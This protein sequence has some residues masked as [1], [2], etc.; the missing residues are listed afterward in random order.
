MDSDRMEGVVERWSAS[1][2]QN[3]HR[4]T[5]KNVLAYRPVVVDAARLIAVLSAPILRFYKTIYLII[6][7]PRQFADQSLLLGD[8]TNFIR[9]AKL[10]LEAV[11]YS[12]VLLA[13]VSFT[14]RLPTIVSEWRMWI[15][16]ASMIGV[17]SLGFYLCA[18]LFVPRGVTFKDLLHFEFYLFAAAAA[19]SSIYSAAFTVVEFALNFLHVR[20]FATVPED[21]FSDALNSC[22]RAKT[23]LL[24][25]LSET[26]TQPGGASFTASLLRA[27]YP[28][29]LLILIPAAIIASRK[30]KV[31]T[32]RASVGCFRDT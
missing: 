14:G 18:Q 24:G 7:R 20:L 8:E 5:R 9:G 23:V 13:M 21:L 4:E 11:S 27:G 1:L 25:L 28:V 31:E 6:F 17:L 22:L 19:V 26:A 32:W 2:L 3:V 30:F 29:Q 16:V 15:L 12:I 10:Y